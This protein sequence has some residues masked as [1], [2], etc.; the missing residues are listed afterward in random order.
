MSDSDIQSSDDEDTVSGDGDSDTEGEFV[1]LTTEANQAWLDEPGPSFT[2]LHKLED[3]D[4]IEERREEI[5]EAYR[6]VVGEEPDDI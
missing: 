3:E 5:R 2:P 1:D 4:E 6:N